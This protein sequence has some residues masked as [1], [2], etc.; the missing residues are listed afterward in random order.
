[1]TQEPTD[2]PKR[3]SPAAMLGSKLSNKIAS[4]A[5]TPSMDRTPSTTCREVAEPGPDV[6]TATDLPPSAGLAAP[7]AT[8]RSAAQD[9][10][11]TREDDIMVAADGTGR[12]VPPGRALGL[13]CGGRGGRGGL[14]FGTFDEMSIDVLRYALISDAMARAVQEQGSAAVYKNVRVVPSSPRDPSRRIPRPLVAAH[15]LTVTIPNLRLEKYKKSF[16]VT[17]VKQEQQEQQEQQDGHRQQ[18]SCCARGRAGARAGRLL[19]P[20][21]GGREPGTRLDITPEPRACQWTP[22]LQEEQSAARG[23][24]QLGAAILLSS[25]R[26]V[27]QADRRTGWRSSAG[28]RARQARSRLRASLFKAAGWGELVQ[29]VAVTKWWSRGLSKP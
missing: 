11:R 2:A 18:A 24:A 21:E 16:H 7:A 19:E 8:W 14:P 15:M 28:S 17:S 13:A 29:V 12:L 9:A 26:L 23:S 1:M 20:L 10:S 22:V 25:T 5:V 6:T 3:N 4:G 27:R